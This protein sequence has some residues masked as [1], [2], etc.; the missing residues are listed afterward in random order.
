MKGLCNYI[1]FSLSALLACGQQ[2]QTNNEQ[3][4]FAGHYDVNK[5]AKVFK[6]PKELDEISGITFHSKASNII[7]AEQDEEGK[8]FACNLNDGSIRKTKFAGKGDY[9]DI[10]LLN[11]YIV[12]LRSDGVLYTF[13]FNDINA[14][15]S[16]NTKEFKHILPGGEYEGLYADN[17]T[18]KLYVLC[19]NCAEKQD[20]TTTVYTLSMDNN[21]TVQSES[22][23][24][25]NVKSIAEKAG[26]KKLSFRP[27]AFT[28]TQDGNEWFILSSV[29]KLIVRTS[30]DFTVKEVYNLDASV[31]NQPEGIALDAAN[32]LYISN[33]KGTSQSATI[34]KIPYRKQG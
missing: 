33:E 23:T 26:L 20:K 31:Y 32:N 13:P 10:Q 29:N 30:A 4:L 34:V 25:I 9:E 15:A 5:P 19:K 27:S 1:L 28:K 8:A 6:M 16:A 12:M 24:T 2:A 22:N 21:G 7:Y 17:K 14:E 11:N 18:S 3:G